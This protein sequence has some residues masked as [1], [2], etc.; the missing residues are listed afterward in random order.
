MR[1]FG[2]FCPVSMATEVLGDRWTPLILRDLIGGSTRFNEIE[3][4]LPN[5][6]RSL[7]AQRLRNLEREGIVERRDGHYL[8]TS[9][10]EDLEPVIFAMGEWSVRWRRTEPRP[11]EIDVVRLLWHMHRGIQVDKLPPGRTVVEFRFTGEDTRHLW[12]VCVK[13]DVSVCATYPGSEGDLVVTV[14]AR[15]LHVVFAGRRTWEQ[16]VVAGELRVDGPAALARA[17]P[18]WF[19]E[20]PWAPAARA[21]AT[22]SSGP[23]SA[24]GPGSGRS[25]GPVAAGTPGTRRRRPPASTRR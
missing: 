22:G 5:I 20:S 14:D 10:G 16:A 21:Q 3:R 15:A 13:E 18:T 24:P 7:L 19:S 1:R 11:D 2:Q 9:A 23:G 4:G 12:L 25:S 17:L 6:S 8:L